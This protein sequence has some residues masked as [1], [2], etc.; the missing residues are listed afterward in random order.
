MKRALTV[1]S[2][3]LSL[4]ALLL[5][6]A[7]HAVC[8]GAPAPLPRRTYVPAPV[9]SYDLTFC[10]GR[11]SI[12]LHPNGAYEASI[13]G[14]QKVSYRGT[15]MVDQGRLWVREWSIGDGTVRVWDASFSFI[16][17]EVIH[18]TGGYGAVDSPDRSPISV[19]LRRVK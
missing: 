12:R 10:G 15:W 5:W 17:D 7:M 6:L 2:L 16:M 1:D 3:I 8:R 13:P 19:V 9:M 14:S 4:F 11:W 18:C